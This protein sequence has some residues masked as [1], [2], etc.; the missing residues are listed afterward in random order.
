MGVTRLAGVVHVMI[1]I[2]RHKAVAFKLL[3]LTLYTSAAT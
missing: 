3:T 2:W 1:P